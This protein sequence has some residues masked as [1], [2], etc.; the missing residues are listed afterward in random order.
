MRETLRWSYDLLPAGERALLRRLSV[1]E[2]APTLEAIDAVCQAA[3]PLETDLLQLAAGLV[4]KNLVQRDAGAGEPRFGLLGTTRA[5]AREL[6]EASGEAEATACAHAEHLRTVVGRD[7]DELTEA[8][9]PAWLDRV[10]RELDDLRAALAWL[11]GRG[12]PAAGL[13]LSAG[14]RQNWELRGSWREGVDTLDRFLVA[15]D[16]AAPALRASSLD[17]GGVLAHRLGEHDGAA[18]R[19]LASL[20]LVREA[21]DVGGVASALNSLGLVAWSRGN[22]RGAAVLLERAI[23]FRRELGEQHAWRCR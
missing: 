4:D 5:F 14:L 19:L 3:G 18:R 2:R 1:F 7:G 15:A 13:E 23:A 8:R 21:T 16:D 6:L 11:H 17:A 9:R 20:A 12:R 22:V 10:E